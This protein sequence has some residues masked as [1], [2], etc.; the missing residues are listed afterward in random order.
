MRIEL[1]HRWYKWI[2]SIIW[3]IWRE[4]DAGRAPCDNEVRPVRRALVPLLSRGV[5]WQSCSGFMC[6]TCWRRVR[7]I[8]VSQRLI[9]CVEDYWVSLH[10]GSCLR[11]FS[12][13]SCTLSKMLRLVM[14]APPPHEVRVLEW[15]TNLCLVEEFLPFAVQ[16]PADNSQGCEFLRRPSSQVVFE[17]FKCF[18]CWMWCPLS[19]SSCGL[20]L[21]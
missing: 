7:N 20:I 10:V 9:S 13:L 8:V 19:V 14:L 2:E 17:D 18:C 11:W 16:K 15:W 6:G 5:S 4:T 1:R 12:S 21:F 3:N